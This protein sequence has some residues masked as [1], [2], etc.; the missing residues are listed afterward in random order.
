MADWISNH[1]FKTAVSIH[2]APSM[3]GPWLPLSADWPRLPR[4]ISFL[5]SEFGLVLIS[6]I[7]KYPR[8]YNKSSNRWGKSSW[9]SDFTPYVVEQSPSETCSWTWSW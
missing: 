6:K 3:T 9:N 5:L 8:N 2:A 4:W 7:Y 1:I